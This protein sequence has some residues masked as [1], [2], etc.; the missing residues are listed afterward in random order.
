[1]LFRSVGT[2][3]TRVGLPGLM[4]LPWAQTLAIFAFAMVSCLVVNDAVKVAMIRWRGLNVVT[5]KPIDVTQQI[6]NRA[7]EL[8]EQKGRH[9]GH[10]FRTGTRRS[11]RFGKISP[12]N[13][14][15]R[16]EL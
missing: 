3:L 10:G 5:K 13:E 6:A 16:T 1:M 2:V 8:Y 15:T 7:Y 11:R 14:L 12:S 9:D 4:P